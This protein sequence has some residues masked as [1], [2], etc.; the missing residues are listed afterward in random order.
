MKPLPP[1]R[2][3]TLL[4]LAAIQIASAQQLTNSNGE[5][6]DT[7]EERAAFK[8]ALELDAVDNTSD[9]D[10][11]VSNATQ[12][13]LDLK[14]PLASP[15]FTG[16]ATF[17]GGVSGINNISVGL[18]FV[19]NIRQY[20]AINP[21]FW[22]NIVGKPTTVADSGLV[23]AVSTDGL[24][25]WTGST[26]ITTLGTI[27]TGTIPVARVSGL[28]TLATQSGTFSG[29]SSGTNTGDQD[30]SGIA[31]NTAAIASNT[32]ALAGKANLTGGNTFS[33]TQNNSGE[34][35]ST[36]ALSG[37]TTQLPNIAQVDSR[38]GR[39]FYTSGEVNNSSTTAAT[40]V[41]ISNLP[42]G[43]YSFT[44][45]IYAQTQNAET[46]DVRTNIL[47]SGGT[48]T[49]RFNHSG[50]SAVASRMLGSGGSTING[51]TVSAPAGGSSE[52]R[53][54]TRY[55]GEM[56]VSSGTATATLT[57]NNLLSGKGE[58]NFW[59]QLQLTKVY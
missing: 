56:V 26:N 16:T 37:N 4:F 7:P 29:T 57:G 40:I 14:A 42:A 41:S 19:D 18:P 12:S 59:A 32:S 36:A 28:G 15:I 25:A 23:D 54:M 39:I 11:P 9:A 10:K 2:K 35:R 22:E 38:C 6:I 45:T 49:R 13:A 27:T 5:N 44:A 48:M 21:P 24:A 47:F 17:T 1:L 20:S 43:T 51:S 33:G 53:T 31:T 58:T 3:I 46:M 34:V 30:I 52:G 50:G 55:F 8:T